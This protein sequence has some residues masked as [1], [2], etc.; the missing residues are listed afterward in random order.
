MEEALPYPYVLQDILKA[1]D[2]IFPTMAPK[3][4]SPNYAINTSIHIE[5]SNKVMSKST[6]PIETML[7]LF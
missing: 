5:I 3:T 2:N 7:E 4:C 1:I 6:V